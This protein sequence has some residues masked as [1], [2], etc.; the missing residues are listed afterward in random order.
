MALAQP[1]LLLAH[2]VEPLED[3]GRV[4]AK[5]LHAPGLEVLGERVEVVGDAAKLALCPA[6]VVAGRGAHPAG[7]AGRLALVA[8][9]VTRRNRRGGVPLATAAARARPR[10]LHPLQRLFFFRPCFCRPRISLRLH[11]RGGTPTHPCRPR[12]IIRWRRRREKNTLGPWQPTSEWPT[13]RRP[14]PAM[15]TGTSSASTI[16][17]STSTAPSSRSSSSAARSGRD[18]GPGLRC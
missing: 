9:V 3:H 14:P 13:R 8:L 2:R 12:K 16:C 4:R 17:A 15:A 6:L 10:A 5:R 11:D 18:A 1:L 7:R